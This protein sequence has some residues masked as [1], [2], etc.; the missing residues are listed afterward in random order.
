MLDAVLNMEPNWHPVI[1]HFAIGLLA[2]AAVVLIVVTLA[3]GGWARRASLQAAGDWMLT[4]GVLAALGAA[5][6]G[7]Y[8]Y[9]TVAHDAPSHTAMT[10]HRNWALATLAIFLLI[11]IWRYLQR[12]RAPS[13]LFAIGLIAAAALLAGTGWRGGRLVYHHGLGV[14]SLPQTSSAGH[15]HDDGN[16][17]E[18]ESPAAAAGAGDA[19]DRETE[20]PEYGGDTP[21]PS[22]LSPTDDLS[23]LDPKGVVAVFHQ[24]LERKD[25]AAVRRLLLP[26]VMI[27]ESGNAERSLS[28]Y[29]SHHMPADMEF[30]AAVK[31]SPQ[32]QRAVTS[33]DTAW[34]LTE[35]VN[36][37]TF[38]GQRVNA[39]TME[40]MVL[41][42]TDLGWRIAHI[43][44]SSA[45]IAKEH[46]DGHDH[47]H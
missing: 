15:A 42:R 37:G 32:G 30:S 12:D 23:K 41:I 29:A 39:R 8:A 22:S 17:H 10:E 27:Y 46:D 3:P 1:V 11:G 4:I 7:F 21:A 25:E 28:Q 34:V 24:A 18:H 33:G 9:Y 26:D 14:A 43:H 13:I 19:H 31:R 38:R 40:T 5:G 45:K 2:T 44:W 36:R 47:E 35:A 6:A 16:G 20:T